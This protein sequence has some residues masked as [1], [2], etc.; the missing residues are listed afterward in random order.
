MLLLK[1]LSRVAREPSLDRHST[2]LASLFNGYSDVAHEAVGNVCQLCS[3]K[4]VLK[5]N[6][7][8]R[9]PFVVTY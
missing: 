5:K 2:H 1:F 7:K 3:N 9:L 6:E 4:G 8:K